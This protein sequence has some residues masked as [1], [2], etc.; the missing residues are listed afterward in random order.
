MGSSEGETMH[1]DDE[2]TNGSSDD[3][4]DTKQLSGEADLKVI[5]LG[6]SAVGKSK[7]VERYLIDDYNPRRLS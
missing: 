7:L 6:D 4:E 2:R 1:N 5:I 3:N